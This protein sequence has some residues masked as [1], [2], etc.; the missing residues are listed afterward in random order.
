MSNQNTPDKAAPHPVPQ[1]GTN[2]RPRDGAALAQERGQTSE[3]DLKGK[4]SNIAETT[5]R[6]ADGTDAPGE[7]VNSPQGASKS[8][9]R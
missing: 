3:R 6:K 7:H 2:E 8:V 5:S 4:R 9:G 1:E